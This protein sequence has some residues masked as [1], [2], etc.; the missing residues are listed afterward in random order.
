MNASPGGA[1]IVKPCLEEIEIGRIVATVVTDTVRAVMQRGD[2]VRLT[3]TG[4]ISGRIRLRG[5]GGN[6]AI[7]GLL[8]EGAV[9]GTGWEGIGS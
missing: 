4:D 3:E 8:E 9:E 2:Q 6:T 5:G 7:L 1:V